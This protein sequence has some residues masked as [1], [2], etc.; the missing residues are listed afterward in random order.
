MIGIGIVI[1]SLMLGADPN[2]GTALAQA[3]PPPSMSVAQAS[4]GVTLLQQVNDAGNAN[5]AP[6]ATPPT[7]Q[8]T[9]APTTAPVVIVTTP[10]TGDMGYTGNPLLDTNLAK[11]AEGKEKV[12]LRQ[13]LAIGFWTGTIQNL[14]VAL[15]SFIPR[16]AV[17]ILFLLVFWIVYRGIRRLV[18]GSMGKAH[19]DQSI[20]DMLSHI[21]KWSVMGFGLVIACNQIGVQITALLTGVSII[22]LAIG[23][24]AQETLAN[25][26]AGIVIFWDKPFRV[27][28][29]VTV[30]GL[31]ARVSRVTFR[32]TR[33]LSLEGE[34]LIFPNTYMLSNRVANHSSHPITRVN[35]SI[36]VAA[37]ISISE[38]RNRL[39][40]LTQG[41]NR[42]SHDPAPEV[43]LD[44]CTPSEMVLVL[45]FWV[46]DEAMQSV[47]RHE[48]MEKAKIALDALAAQEAAQK[49]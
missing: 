17:A 6:A 48:Y 33:L 41:D 25:F 45:R 21:I 12:T 14:V 36:T 16:V 15:L 44:Q 34:T 24:A 26:I 47:L 29:W 4:S 35:V 27:G 19:V 42:L 40:K 49:K 37:T 8:P 9:T 2:A 22:G 23:F 32:S 18:I 30:D 39:L 5:N 11:L 31:F 43:V 20:R 1:L 38:A 13:V 3:P 28:E 10:G 7:T 46:T